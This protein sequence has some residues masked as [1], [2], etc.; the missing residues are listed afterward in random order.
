VCHFLVAVTSF[1]TAVGLGGAILLLLVGTQILNWYWLVL[2]FGAGLAA[3]AYRS[4]SEI[5]SG[6]KIAQE[7]DRRLGFEDALSTAYYFAEQPDRAASPRE[8]VDRQR[9]MAE[10]LARSADIGRGLPF[11]AP[12]TLYVNAALAVLACGMFGLRYGIQRNL[13]LRPSLVRIA[14]EGFL[15]PSREVAEA[16]KGLRPSE[17]EKEPGS[18]RDSGDSKSSDDR[19]ADRDEQW[20]AAN[21]QDGSNPNRAVDSKSKGK[22][23]Q[24]EQKAPGDDSP[25]S[26]DANDPAG[27]NQDSDGN[28]RL[29]TDNNSKEGQQQGGSK[30]SNRS[31]GDNDKSSLADKLRDALSNLLAKLKPQPKS[32]EAQQ[33]SGSQ[34]QNAQQGKQQQNQKQDGGPKAENSEQADANAGA[35]SEGEQQQGGTE[36]SQGKSQGSSPERPNSPDGKSGIG[37]QNGDKSAREAAEL[38]TMGKISEIL[39]KRAANI[40]GEVM[41]EVSSG[42]QQ[43]KTQ[44]SERDAQHAEAGGEINRDEIPLAYQQYVQQYFEQ[45]R[46]LPAAQNKGSSEKR[47]QPQDRP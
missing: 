9:Q 23:S 32:N 8:F 18:A 10:E 40:S 31:G 21:D 15:G 5:F 19:D 16:K 33:R 43:L 6:Y 1:A 3:G 47:N 30:D 35:E 45:I 29:S 27:P 46:K 28:S 7:I 34:S 41:V 14:F 44:Y 42:K 24:T 22:D 26:A 12:R 11:L 36:Q 25:D 37:N 38:A 4:R 39:G 20:S 13:D 17:G 2:L